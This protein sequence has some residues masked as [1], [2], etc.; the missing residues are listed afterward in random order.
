[1]N[2]KGCIQVIEQGTRGFY[3]RNSLYLPFHCEI[4]SIWVGREM[5]FIAAP[6]LLCDMMDSE[7]LAL[8]EGDRY[9]NLVFRKW[10]DM[11]KELGNNKGHVILFAAE[12]GSDLFQAEQRFY[13]RITFELEPRELSF[14]LLDNPFYL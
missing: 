5:S 8:R 9:T 10:G 3:I 1:M 11:A 13:I 14:E 12:K 6:E 2:T 4:L 7:V